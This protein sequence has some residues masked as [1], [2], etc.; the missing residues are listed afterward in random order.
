MLL[1]ATSAIKLSL[2]MIKCHRVLLVAAGRLH[3]LYRSLSLKH[4]HRSCYTEDF[5]PKILHCFIEE[6]YPASLEDHFKTFSHLACHN[7]VRSFILISHNQRT[8]NFFKIKVPFRRVDQLVD[9]GLSRWPAVPL[10]F[11]FGS[12]V[13]SALLSLAWRSAASRLIKRQPQG[14]LTEFQR[15]LSQNARQ[16]RAPA[17]CVNLIFYFL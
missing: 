16:Y 12:S 7:L 3:P 14:S 9:G 17:M 8:F 1:F 13:A 2:K 6:P 5:S 4:L 10:T 11:G 15:S